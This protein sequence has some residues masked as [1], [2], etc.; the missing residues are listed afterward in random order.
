MTPW[1]TKEQRAAI[2]QQR[3]MMHAA[4][5]AL[6]EYMTHVALR[7]YQHGNGMDTP[8]ATHPEKEKQ[9]VPAGVNFAQALR[10]SGELRSRYLDHL[11]GCF[12]DERIDLAELNA[13]MDAMMSANTEDE[14]K[15]L[16]HDLPVL[17]SPAILVVKYGAHWSTSMAYLTASI[18]MF[19]IAFL[20]S[21]LLSD[22]KGQ[23]IFCLSFVWMIAFTVLSLVTRERKEKK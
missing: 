9:L 8:L 21:F 14:L 15:F 16:I 22:L 11:R 3:D 12:E 13:R 20:G 10:V 17:P 23:A 7:E 19:V 2:Q 1:Y 5:P 6:R 18:G 4:L